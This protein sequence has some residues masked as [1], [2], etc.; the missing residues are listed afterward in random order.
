[1][2]SIAMKKNKTSNII[3]TKKM[4]DYSQDAVFKKKADE[5]AAFLTKNGMPR[6]FARKS[7]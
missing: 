5:A 6:N 1:M 7:K 3:V 4:K 2:T